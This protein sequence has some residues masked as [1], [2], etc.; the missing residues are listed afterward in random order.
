MCDGVV[1]TAATKARRPGHRNLELQHVTL[2]HHCNQSL[3]FP[4]CKMGIMTPWLS[5]LYR[6]VEGSKEFPDVK[7]LWV[8]STVRE[9]VLLE[10]GQGAQ[11]H[12]GATGSAPCSQRTCETAAS[13]A[14]E[15]IWCLPPAAACRLPQ[16]SGIGT[17]GWGGGRWLFQYLR[18]ACPTR[19]PQAPCGPGRL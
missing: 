14:G 6:I 5:P 8:L 16:P 11:P 3:R 2:N 4:T 10:S 15:R 9:R 17:P 1:I 13:R 7:M 19:S 18:P 12:P